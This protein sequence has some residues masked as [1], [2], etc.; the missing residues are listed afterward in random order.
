MSSK[1]TFHDNPWPQGHKI[2]EFAWTGRLE[3]E[4]GLWFDLHLKTEKYYA[5]DTARGAPEETGEAISD[6][7]SKIVWRNYH[8][9][10]L[11][12]IKWGHTRGLQVGSA[13]APLDWAALLGGELAVDGLPR[14]E[15]QPPAFGLYLLG[16]DAAADHRIR[17]AAGEKAGEYTIDWRGKIALAYAGDY[18]YRYSFTAR[19]AA[20]EFA[21]FALPEGMRPRQAR[22]AMAGLVRDPAGYRLV[23]RKGRRWY[24]RRAG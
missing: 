5:E 6:W 22:A 20:A 17:F 12:S 4:T 11:S 21:G 7:D 1:I 8:A 9:G 13:A 18:D 15:A 24:V 19:I 23:R 16:H 10:I 3:A 14:D 2:V